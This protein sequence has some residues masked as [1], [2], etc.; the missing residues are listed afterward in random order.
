MPRKKEP[1]EDLSNMSVDELIEKWK[2]IKGL[3][4]TLEDDYR[5]AEISED[6]Y[7][8]AKEKNTKKFSQLTEI[9]AGWGITQDQLEEKSAAGASAGAAAE[10]P[11]EKEG[12]AAGT[13]EAAKQ[14][15]GSGAKA[16][17]SPEAAPGGAATAAPAQAAVAAP[18]QPGVSM[19]VIEA[20]VDAK[21]EK[22]KANIETMKET[23]AGV[24][25]R[26]Q[27]INESVGELRSQGAQ[28]ESVLKDTQSKVESLGEEI[29]AINPTKFSKELE[30]R[31]K[32]AG[33]QDMRIEKLEVKE[34]EIA[35]TVGEIR[36]LLESIG[37]L[38]NIAT[39]SKEI[40]E[41]MA[42][43]KEIANDMKKLSTK[44][45]RM[46]V[47]LNKRM[48]DFAVYKS[49]QESM[50]GVV[51]DVIK[52]LDVLSVRMDDYVTMSN[53]DNLK[54][55]ISD[56]DIRV[57]TVKN[58]IGKLIPVARMK[59]PQQISDLQEEREAIKSLIESIESE[60]SEGK[61]TKGRYSI[62][63]KKNLQKLRGIEARLKTEWGRFEKMVVR[64]TKGETGN[65]IETKIPVTKPTAA[66]PSIAKPATTRPVA[67]KPAITKP[68]AKRKPLKPI[69]KKPMSIKQPPARSKPMKM[70]TKV[71]KATKTGIKPKKT[72]VLVKERK[73]LSRIAK[74]DKGAGKKPGSAPGAS[75]KRK[76]PVVAKTVKHA[77]TRAKPV[78]SEAD[79]MLSAL[80]DSYKKGL[81]SKEAY[82]STKKMLRKGK[83]A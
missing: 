59:I 81:L 78:K 74:M 28:R 82:E 57:V 56:L 30:K 71:M 77:E 13:A 65:K 27:T 26:M 11:D 66:K 31:D 76:V 25:E 48:E 21:I 62:A 24:S 10:K 70:A 69:A 20:K 8:E 7:K 2:Q 38:E 67:T 39:V 58:M 33:Q 36:K 64:A 60:Y 16:K 14:P 50:E 37:G 83:T 22:V 17:P 52:S 40:G 9:L 15:A 49:K 23:N 32:T 6:A 51:K 73:V 44:T 45:E 42:D 43:V 79:S 47:S 46:Y 54:K 18:A 4:D 29:S 19:D 5:G 35:K 41:K 34:S 3:L 75:V 80:E 63:A 1:K 68:V 55:T 72:G 61:L 12:G 53:F